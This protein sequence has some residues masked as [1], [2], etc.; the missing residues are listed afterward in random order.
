MLNTPCQGA[1]LV[2]SGMDGQGGSVGA[3]EPCQDD[4]LGLHVE[5]RGRRLH[6]RVELQ[7]GV[8]CPFVALWWSSI[9]VDQRRFDPA[10]RMDDQVGPIVCGFGTDAVAHSSRTIS[11]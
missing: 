5:V 3:V 11:S 10:D 9:Q 6:Q 8:R 2:A 1:A 4:D 7:P